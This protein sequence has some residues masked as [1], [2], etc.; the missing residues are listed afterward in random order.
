[1][2]EFNPI[3]LIPFYN[4]FI[5]FKEFL[6]KILIYKIP[7]LVVDDGSQEEESKD[8]KN[9]CDE[10]KIFYFHLD[11]NSGKGGAVLRGFKISRE[12]GFSHVLQIDADGQHDSK[13]IEKFLMISKENQNAIING[14]PHCDELQPKERNFGHK[15]ANFWVILETHSFDI[16]DVMCGFRVYPLKYI[17]TIPKIY[18]LRMGFDIEIIVKAYW[19]KILII[20]VDTKVSYNGKQVSHFHLVKDN[21]KLSFLHAYLCLMGILKIFSR[22]YRR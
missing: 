16:K 12:K 15:F 9:L 14:V 5:Q 7:I 20:N 17:E 2:N 10:N 13:D 11:K 19:K 21:I 8:L 22:F 4:H 3:V 6:P 1:M 18:F